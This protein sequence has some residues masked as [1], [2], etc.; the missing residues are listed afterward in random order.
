[1]RGTNPGPVAKVG[2]SAEHT[3]RDKSQEKS[4]SKHH[5]INGLLGFWENGSFSVKSDLP[6]DFGMPANHI[7]PKGE[8]MRHLQRT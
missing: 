3:V 7:G 8:E 6:T 1:M 4:R 2:Y 5:Y